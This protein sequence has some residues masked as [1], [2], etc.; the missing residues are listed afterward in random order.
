M[1]TPDRV[2][3]YTVW[4]MRLGRGVRVTLYDGPDHD[5]AQKA[6]DSAKLLDP[7]LYAEV[8]LTPSWRYPPPE[9]ARGCKCK[10]AP[11]RQILCPWGHLTSCHWPLE[12]HEAECDRAQESHE[13]VA[14]T[15]LAPGMGENTKLATW[16]SLGV[17]VA[18]DRVFADSPD[19]GDPACLCS[20]CGGVIEVAPIRL[21]PE[22]GKD[23]EMRFHAECLG[24]AV[25]GSDDE[26]E[27]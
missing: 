15:A 10:E 11:N 5:V 14:L 2:R 24:L 18:H 25:P 7:P 20:R 12:C 3:W 8:V 21:W 26:T 9:L 13:A 27:A 23:L 17:D 6:G 1:K 22:P 19:E 4:G 16:L